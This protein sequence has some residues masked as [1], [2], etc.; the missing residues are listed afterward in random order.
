MAHQNLFLFILQSFFVVV[1]FPM[2]MYET[3]IMERDNK[4][5]NCSMPFFT[6]IPWRLYPH[7]MNGLK[8]FF[9]TWQSSSAI[10]QSDNFYTLWIVLSPSKTFLSDFKTMSWHKHPLRFP[11]QSVSNARLRH[12]VFV[13]LHKLLSTML[14]SH[15]NK[16]SNGNVTQMI[17]S[18]LGSDFRLMQK[19][20]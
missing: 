7:M 11:T 1:V 16:T 20:W 6:M 8:T 12:F 3:A 14:S 10:L 4:S 5:N 17:Y 15:W 18:W 19:R 2:L 9:L 13:K